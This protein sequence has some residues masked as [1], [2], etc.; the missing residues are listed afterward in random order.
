MGLFR[1]GLFLCALATAL[2]AA[3]QPAPSRSEAQRH[4]ELG[5]RY[6]DTQE[7]ERAITEFRASYAQD[8]RPEALYALG[9]A[10]RRSG[11]C[12]GAL[13]SYRAFMR[14]KGHDARVAYKV[15]LQI[16]RC[17]EDLASQASTTP[18]GHETPGPSSA[19]EVPEASPAPVAAPVPA[20]GPTTPSAPV[21]LVGPS[22]GEQATP[23]V[24]RRRT[25][26]WVGLTIGVVALA[27]GAATA[28][29]IAAAPGT[30]ATTIGNFMLHP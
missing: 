11:D 18:G 10:Q 26:L 27:A 5:L 4:Y 7:Y 24:H 30:P 20:P 25:A 13:D 15:Q 29:A 19:P 17:Q 28:I 2:P 12:H 3:A 22:G 16:E 1:A 23:S 21:G 6:F 9:Q 14:H 8:P